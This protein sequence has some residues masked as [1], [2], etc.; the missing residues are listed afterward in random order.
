MQTEH[1]KGALTKTIGFAE[2]AATTEAG[3]D[4]TLLRNMALS[5]AFD[6]LLN[7]HTLPANTIEKVRSLKEQ[8]QDSFQHLV[9]MQLKKLQ[10]SHASTV[11]SLKRM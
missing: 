3:F 8:Q 4:S 11:V 2:A 6:D 10:I 7:A 5:R 9:D 1:S